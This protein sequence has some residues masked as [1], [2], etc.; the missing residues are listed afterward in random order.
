MSV[1]RNPGWP[2]I[3]VPIGPSIPLSAMSARLLNLQCFETGYPVSL[4]SIDFTSFAA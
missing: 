3:A 4:W 2:R 1:L